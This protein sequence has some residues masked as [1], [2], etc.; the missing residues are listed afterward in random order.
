M[1]QPNFENIVPPVIVL[2]AL[3]QTSSKPNSKKDD[4]KLNT[5]KGVRPQSAPP[6]AEAA[7]FAQLATPRQHHPYNPLPWGW[8][9]LPKK[10][11]PPDIQRIELLAK[12]RKIFDKDDSPPARGKPHVI[13]PVVFERLT[14]PKK[15]SQELIDRYAIPIGKGSPP[16]LKRNKKKDERDSI[17]KSSI[18]RSSGER[19]LRQD[20]SLGGYLASSRRPS[21]AQPRRPPSGIG[22]QLPPIIEPTSRSASVIEAASRQ[23]SQRRATLPKSSTATRPSVINE[24]NIKSSESGTIATISNEI[25]LGKEEETVKSTESLMMA[26]NVPLPKSGESTPSARAGSSVGDQSTQK[27]I[28]SLEFASNVPLPQSGRDTPSLRS[29]SVENSSIGNNLKQKST[30]SLTFAS[31]VPLPMSGTGSP[32]I[33]DKEK[34]S[35]TSPT[36]SLTSATIVPL[37][38]CSGDSM[39]S[40]EES[41]GQILPSRSNENAALRNES[42]SHFEGDE[43]DVA[44][45]SPQAQFSSTL[46]LNVAI[47]IPLP[48]SREGSENEDDPIKNSKQTLEVISTR[49][50][51]D[52]IGPL[53]TKNEPH[54]SISAQPSEIAR[55]STSS[56]SEKKSQMFSNTDNIDNGEDDIDKE[57][58][59]K[60][61]PE[62]HSVKGEHSESLGIPKDL[63]S[64]ESANTDRGN[65]RFSANQGSR[66]SLGVSPKDYAAL[67]LRPVNSEGEFIENKPQTED[68]T[69]A[70][71]SE[72]RHTNG[73]ACDFNQDNGGQ[74]KNL[75]NADKDIESVPDS[76]S[77]AQKPI[78]NAEVV[79]SSHASVK[80]SSS[81]QEQSLATIPPVQTSLKEG[82]IVPHPPARSTQNSSHGS[83]S[84]GISPRY[85]IGAKRV[86]R[87]ASRSASASAYSVRS[88]QQSGTRTP[89]NV[90]RDELHVPDSQDSGSEP[91]RIMVET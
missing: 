4:I 55:Q 82:S 19:P 78:E 67:G 20:G 16:K 57:D 73:N 56:K 53:A 63:S 41:V 22:S 23:Q 42:K 72:T 50:S 40:M 54:S 89:R 45:L 68:K 84:A 75:E 70:S 61:N 51:M 77:D 79:E 85:S 21:T 86:S 11:A 18:R 83:L 36:D 12:P 52:E 24:T 46:T 80:Q 65:E 31:Q 44:I 15:I 91:E 33:H 26:S 59:I 34:Q 38:E 48:L 29:E 14:S 37:P 25:R 47:H 32:L 39:T 17:R 71:D 60:S 81:L 2:K 62:N 90:V 88:R 69:S 64:E 43:T 74:E 6:S 8:S 1:M 30:E 9:G 66:Q 10:S 27:S 3:D 28:I 7:Y 87:S 58:H 35:A 76:L 49:S 5:R 13:D